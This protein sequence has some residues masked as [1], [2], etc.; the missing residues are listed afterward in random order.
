MPPVSIPVMVLQPGVGVGAIRL[1]SS[2]TSCL[3]QIAAEYP[4]E[5]AFTVSCPPE[6]ELFSD[7]IVLNLPDLGINLRFDPLRQLLYIIDIYDLS[8]VCH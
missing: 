3:T 2:L 8:K 7:D 1:L 4:R 5:A 6:K